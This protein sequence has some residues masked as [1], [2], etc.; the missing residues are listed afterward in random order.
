MKFLYLS[1]LI[2]SVL[3]VSC[4]NSNFIDDEINSVNVSTS[5]VSNLIASY[6]LSFEEPNDFNIKGYEDSGIKNETD[7]TTVPET[8]A[9]EEIINYLKCKIDE[10]KNAEFSKMKSERVADDLFR[11]GV[12]KI[13]T[14]GS[15][16]EFVYFMDCED[17]GWTSIDN[18]FN[19]PFA[20]EVDRN[21]N[22]RFRFCLVPTSFYS[23]YV[24]HFGT[25]DPLS[26]VTTKNVLERYHD[27]EDSKNQNN[28]ESQPSGLNYGGTHFDKNT[29]FMWVFQEGSGKNLGF[30]YGVI[31]EFG[32]IQ[33]NIDDENKSN[34]NWHRNTVRDS[35]GNFHEADFPKDTW[36][37]GFNLGKNTGYKVAIRN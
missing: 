10:I 6:E 32:T 28:I 19:Q 11:V 29:L 34:S 3:L 22:F 23:G 37:N 2:I 16:P 14:C 5:E 18:P 24:L 31:H 35:N 1:A 12:F 7:S 8:V 4:E 36:I 17:G 13:Q 21:G 9:S 25:A 15:Y 27:N 20:S 26:L 33:L 30:Q